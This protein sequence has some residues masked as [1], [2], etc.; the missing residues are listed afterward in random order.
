MSN[1]ACPVCGA[2][3]KNRSLQ[4]HNF[5]FASLAGKYETMPESVTERLPTVEHFRKFALIKT[6]HRDE[7]SITCSSLAEA[8]RVA[9]FVRPMDEFA[10]VNVTGATVIAWTAK[11]QSLKAMGRERFEQSK[12][13]VLA[14]ADSLLGITEAA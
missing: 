5:F 7:R 8:R 10:L 2:A 13:D 3:R 9:A 14:Y 11:S 12:N 6:G 1:D 4:S